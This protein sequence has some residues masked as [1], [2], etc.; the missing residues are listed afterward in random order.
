MTHRRRGLKIGKIYIPKSTLK[1]V[2]KVSNRLATDVETD[3]L[4]PARL[5]GSFGNAIG[6]KGGPSLFI[7]AIIGVGGF[8]AYKYVSK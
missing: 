7:I 8:I 3:A 2:G 6:G 4:A 5:M 1:A